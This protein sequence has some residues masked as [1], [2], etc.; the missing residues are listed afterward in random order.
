MCVLLLGACGDAGRTATV[1]PPRQRP[2]RPRP[3][4]SPE[5][6]AP[7]L[8]IASSGQRLIACFRGTAR[9]PAQLLARIRRGEL[10][11]V[12]LF[13]DNADTIAATRRLAD[14]LQAIPRPPGCA[15]RCWS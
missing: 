6:V 7:K 14:R 9:P 1:P 2:R 11:G 4:T 5:A 15:T 3:P 8:T 10:A 13:A 12:V